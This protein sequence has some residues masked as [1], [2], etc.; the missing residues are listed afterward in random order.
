M[1]HQSFGAPCLGED[2]YK[3]HLEILAFLQV[4]AT[5]LDAFAAA[6]LVFP[7]YAGISHH[8]EV[9]NVFLWAL[10]SPLAAAFL[11]PPLCPNLLVPID[12][13]P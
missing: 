5:V 1:V 10:F 12:P 11:L 3:H 4:S 9:C 6:D 7:S 13:P 2:G 8:I